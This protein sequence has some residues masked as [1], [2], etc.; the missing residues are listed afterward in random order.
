MLLG[1]STIVAACGPRTEDTAPEGKPSGD[2][3]G[4]EC[5]IDDECGDGEICES[6]ACI[7]GDRNNELED[8]EALV[9]EE[10]NEGVINPAGDV[11]WYSVQ[12]EGGEFFRVTAVTAEA[13]GGLDSVVS[14]YNAAGQRLVWED[15]HP[16]GNVS[17][18]D[19]MVFGYFPEA[20]TWYIKVEDVGTFDGGDGTGGP[21]ETYTLQIS[22]WNSVISEPDSAQEAGLDFGDVNPDTY[23]SVPLVFEEAGD[24]DYAVLDLPDV[25]A[26]I[27]VMALEHAN[28]DLTPLV[29]LYNADGEKVLE[30]ESPTAEAPALLPYPLG[31]HYVL[32]ISDADGGGGSDYWSWAFFL[33]RDPGSGNEPGVEP[34]DDLASANVVDLEDQE[35]DSGR[36]YAAY[37]QGYVESPTDTDLYTFDVPFDDAYVTVYIGAGEYGS[38]LSPRLELLDAS[39]TTL[40]T[41]DTTGSEAEDAVN[42]GPYAQGTYTLRV[43]ATP[44]SAAEGGEGYFYLF[45]LH[46]TSFEVD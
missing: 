18:A 35:P 5:S 33:L 43:S 24:G 26:P 27:Y 25:G 14:V 22:E 4:P 39:G 20:G 29:N 8:A 3:S 31:T 21:D 44:D 12:A 6:D 34:D 15:E 37:R 13:E 23:Y 16:G 30:L 42:L 1:L 45:G 10:T 46:A 36:W 11:D 32:G 7:D 17:S 2:D 38:L 41:V 9:W 40:E 19:S 28:T